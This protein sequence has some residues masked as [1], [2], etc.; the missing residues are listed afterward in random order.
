MK[1][2]HF[3]FFFVSSCSALYAQSPM[4]GISELRSYSA[5]HPKENNNLRETSSTESESEKAYLVEKYIPEEFRKHP[6]FLKK[7]LEIA[8][9]NIELIQ[10][11]T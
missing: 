2:L 7:S 3:L 1:C 5:S 9:V 4:Q 11:R 10:H 8:S 6:E